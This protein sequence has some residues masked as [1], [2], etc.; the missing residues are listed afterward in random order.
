M[1]LLFTLV[2]NFCI[3][4]L[5]SQVPVSI[6][7]HPEPSQ[8]RSFGRSAAISHD[9]AVIGNNTKND[10]VG[11]ISVFKRNN[12]TWNFQTDIS[13]S[14]NLTGGWFGFSCS[15]TDNTMAVGAPSYNWHPENRTG[16]AFIFSRQEDQ[17]VEEEILIPDNSFART[18]F[19]HTINNNDN[20]VIVGTPF[21]REDPTNNDRKG[22]ATIYKKENGEWKVDAILNPPADIEWVLYFSNSISIQDEWA[23]V[24]G[25]RKIDGEIT[26]FIAMYQNMGDSWE[27]RQ[28]I[29]LNLFHWVLDVAINNIQLH[30]DKMIVGGYG[31]YFFDLEL[32][33]GGLFVYELNNGVWTLDQDLKPNDYEEEEMGKRVSLSKNFAISGTQKISP[34]ASGVEQSILIY[35]RSDDENWKKFMDYPLP[36]K[37]SET[38]NFQVDACNS[39][40][41]V[42][43]LDY[44]AVEESHMGQAIIFDLRTFSSN[45]NITD[46]PNITM[47][48][49]PTQDFLTIRS[50]DIIE[51]ISLFDITGKKIGHFPNVNDSEAQINVKSLLSGPYSV[52]IHSNKNVLTRKFLKH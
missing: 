3:I 33:V 43:N 15:M 32:G 27:L 12:D 18:S 36:F 5:F 23:A 42:S 52:T 19:G 46:E 26:N 22:N 31:P 34:S 8:N 47:F 16:Q 10:S 45:E 44:H 50:S 2:L 17:W 6:I 29:D 11:A 25:Y 4:S 41:I 24:G 13:P 9:F 49:N 21:Y 35:E 37:F 28:V 1:K 40:A 38:S 20:Y 30:D 14:T 51:N 39:F 7:K 48:P